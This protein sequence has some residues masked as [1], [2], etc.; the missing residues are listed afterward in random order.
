VSSAFPSR[1]PQGRA[2]LIGA[3]TPAQRQRLLPSSA[4]V[5]ALLAA[6][7]V[8]TLALA[9]RAD[10]YVYWSSGS[11]IG[12]A[13]LDGTGVNQSFITGI[14]SQFPGT[15]DPAVDGGHIYWANSVPGTIGRANLDG[16]DPNQSLITGAVNPFDVAVDAGHVYWTN[17]GSQSIGR[18]NL[19][20]TGV[21]Q[22]F[23]SV[24]TFPQGIAVDADHVYWTNY[25]S[26]T[27]GRASLD[28]SGANENFIDGASNPG[29]VAVD[30]GHAYWS[31]FTTATIGRANLDGTGV[32][33][34]FISAGGPPTGVAVDAGHIY[35]GNFID[36]IRRADLDGTGTQILISGVGIP[37][38]I[39]VDALP[40]PTPTTKAQCRNGGWKQF[41][42]K[43]QGRCVGFVVLTRICDALERHGIHLKFCP[44]TPPD[45][46]RPN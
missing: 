42:F 34:S 19:D 2:K 20:G 14:Q 9:P 43:N 45:P 13:N 36:T 41:G 24:A 11:I 10:A 3:A 26:G 17:L 12:R 27:I 21:N 4:A 7:L 39:A 22:S 18:A 46:L 16:S 5:L 15:G 38:G 40:L 30:A 1:I 29:D 32:N 37:T 33:Q 6:L 8:S 25:Y 28:G 35:W 23:I 44:P 31:N